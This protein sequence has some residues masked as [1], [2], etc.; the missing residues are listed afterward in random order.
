MNASRCCVRAR[1]SVLLRARARG[2]ALL[3]HTPGPAHQLALAVR[4]YAIQGVGAGRAKRALVTAD[5]SAVIRRSQGPGALFAAFAHL[6]SHGAT[7]FRLVEQLP[8]DQHPPDL[9]R[10]RADLI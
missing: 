3:T 4:A 9:T 8:A 6:E 2:C 7:S 1:C 5:I 10:P